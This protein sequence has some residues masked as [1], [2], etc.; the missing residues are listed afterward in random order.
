[1]FKQLSILAVWVLLP[2]VHVASFAQ[3][4]TGRIIGTVSDPSGAVVPGAKVTITNTATDFSR[5]ATT[6]N[7]GSYQI[8]LVP[9]G[10]YTVAAE[11]PGFRKTVTS[12][13]KLDR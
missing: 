10:T 2:S 3:D 8:L 7:D 9:V 13:Q 12:P 4:S 6:D 1:M 5:S 11:A